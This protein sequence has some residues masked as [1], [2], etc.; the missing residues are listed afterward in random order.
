MFQEGRSGTRYSEYAKRYNPVEDFGPDMLYVT[1]RC[2]L[3]TRC[4]R[5][6]EDVAGNAVLNVSER[7]DR[8]YIGIERGA[9]AGPS[10]GRQRGGSLPGR[11]AH[12]Q[13]LPAQGAGLGPGQ[14]RRASAPAA[15]RAATPRSI[16]GTTPWCGCARGPN[17][18]VN[19]HF[20]CDHGRMNYRWMNRG[21]RI[22]APLVRDGSRH[23]ATGW[24][25]GTEPIRRSWSRKGGR[26]VLLASGGASL[27]SLGHAS[28][29]CSPGPRS[30]RRYR[31]PVAEQEAAAPGRAGS[32]AP[33]GAGA[34]RIEGARLLGY[35]HRL[36]RR[37]CK[38]AA[39]C[40]DSWCCST[41]TL[42]EAEAA[43]DRQRR[44]GGGA[45]DRCS[46]RSC[47]RAQLVLPVTNVAEESGTFV[48][49]DRRVQ[50]YHQ[51]RSAPGMAR[52]AWWVCSATRAAQPGSA[53]P[54]TAAE[55]FA[56][57]AATIPAHGGPDLRGPRRHRPSGR[58]RHARTRRSLLMTPEIKGLLLVSALKLI[59]VFTITLVGVALLTLMERKVSAWMQYRLGPNRVGLRRAAA[60]RRRRP[61][62]HSQGRDLPGD[63]NAVLF[64]LAP[65]LA[66]IPALMLGSVIPW[67]APLPVDIRLHAAARSAAS[68]YDGLMPMAVA[69][70]PIG[71]LFV[72][73][74]SSMGVYGI[75]LAA[76]RP[77][78]STRCSAASGPARRWSPTRWRWD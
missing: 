74:V 35:S 49:R 62:E 27:E 37:R 51:A 16:P 54:A 73:A 60:A 30:P 47:R 23:T 75:A 31:L 61:Q 55:A 19:R 34:Q 28:S 76:G 77:T 59:V 26:A 56:A 7:G 11:V 25:R 65:A 43:G 9:A 20:I 46:R 2:I 42:T 13:G 15:P 18:E 29:A 5:F 17:L 70:L 50:R 41:S 22:E 69:D 12:L 32:G 58:R 78:A 72:L 45:G 36:E 8:A 64:M 1:N 4:V 53:Q 10:V 63:A 44:R 39:S 14:D 68:V 67:A 66:F 40:A 57:I 24:D 71:F 48:N 3:C 21:D 38:A 6:M 52:P 33:E